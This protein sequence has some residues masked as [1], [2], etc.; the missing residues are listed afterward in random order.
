MEFITEKIEKITSAIIT[1]KTPPSRNPEYYNGQV[2]WYGPG[3]LD[4]SPI[5]GE[6]QRTITQKAV[7]DKKAKLIPKE[8][9]LLGCIGDIGKVGML[10][11]SATSNQQITALVPNK[12]VDYRYLFYWLKS[13]KSL[14]QSKASNAILPILN[15]RVLNSIKISY[16]KSLDN[17]KRIA[18][19]LTDCEELITKRK[20]SIALLNELLKST[21]LELFGDRNGEQVTME[22]VIDIQKGQVNPNEKPY[23]EMYHVGGSNIESG[24]G[25]L[26]NLKKA[27]EENLISGKYLFEPGYLLYSKIRPYLNKVSECYLES[28]DVDY[29]GDRY[30]THEGNANGAP[31]VET[32]ITL[33]F[34]EIELITR[35]RAEQGF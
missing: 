16:P 33:Q 28:M 32:T 6:S 14:L 13:N 8:S 31:P 21:F 12:K 20:E 34:G 25:K 5:L 35:E 30:K 3:D 7:T 9:V 4:K 15:N 29:G 17:Q 10:T 22:E 26:Q 11:H 24:T 2:N 27:G 18:Q 19:V 1:G 23:S